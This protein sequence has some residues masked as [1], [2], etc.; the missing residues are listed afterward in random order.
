MEQLD[1]NKKKVRELTSNIYLIR[2]ISSVCKFEFFSNRNYFVGLMGLVGFMG[3]RSN[4]FES[5]YGISS[6]NI[7]HRILP[8]ESRQSRENV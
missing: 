7:A 3:K 5:L 4:W 1:W 6:S 8:A 2:A